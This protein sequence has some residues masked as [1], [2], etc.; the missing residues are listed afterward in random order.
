MYGTSTC[1]EDE[2]I[3]EN[4]VCG[5]EAFIA[6]EGVGAVGFEENLIVG[7]DGVEVITTSP[8]YWE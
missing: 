3:L 6:W 2:Y 1:N 7:K 5:S 8:I 4:M